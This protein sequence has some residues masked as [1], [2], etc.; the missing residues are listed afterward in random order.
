MTKGRVDNRFTA[1]R[2]QGDKQKEEAVAPKGSMKSLSVKGRS[3][4]S[5]RRSILL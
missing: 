1:V 4:Q 3:Y 5:K 2:Y